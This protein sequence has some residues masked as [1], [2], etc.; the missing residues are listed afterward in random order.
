MLIEIHRGDIIIPTVDMKTDRIRPDSNPHL[1]SE[2]IPSSSSS[3]S[4][5]FSVREPTSNKVSDL[6]R[7]ERRGEE[8]GG[9]FDSPS[10]TSLTVTGS[11][12]ALGS[13]MP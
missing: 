4:S 8:R 7:E 12:S 9:V 6:I 5:G 2:F 3:A 10:S 11:D 13:P 1:T